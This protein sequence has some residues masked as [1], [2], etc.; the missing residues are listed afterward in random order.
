M[1]S[2]IL[3]YSIEIFKNENR[4]GNIPPTSSNISIINNTMTSNST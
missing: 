3:N 1:D 4:G 2:S